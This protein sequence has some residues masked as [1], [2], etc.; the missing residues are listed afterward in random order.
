MAA[1][2]PLA[3]ADTDFLD[4]AIEH[5]ERVGDSLALELPLFFDQPLAAPDTAYTLSDLGHPRLPT[6]V[7]W[8]ELG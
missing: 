5:F 3:P 4:A 2:Q 6:L 7:S 8:P 1:R